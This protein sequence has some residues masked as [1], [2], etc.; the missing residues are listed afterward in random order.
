MMSGGASSFDFRGDT[1]AFVA[2][3][4][5]PLHSIATLTISAKQPVASEVR[6]E[7]S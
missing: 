4:E 1:N 3:G 6:P 2:R 7:R 5:S